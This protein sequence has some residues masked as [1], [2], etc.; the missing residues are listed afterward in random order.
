MDLLNKMKFKCNYCDIINFYEDA[1][2][3]FNNCRYFPK[4]C[5]Q[6]CGLH[7]DP[8]LMKFHCLSE[9]QNTKFSCFSCS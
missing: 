7:L 6:G 8:R 5:I 3:H 9:C 4:T 1:I 2:V